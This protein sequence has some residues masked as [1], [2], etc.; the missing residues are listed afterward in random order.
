MS[1]AARSKILEEMIIEFGRKGLKL[2]QN[3][4]E[5]LKSARVLMK[6]LDASQSDRGETAPK[7]DEYLGSVEAY[8]VTE[9]GKHFPSEKVDDWLRKLDLAGCESC[10]TVVKPREEMRFIPGVPRDQKWIRVKPLASL[11]LEKL[12]QMAAETRLGFR[13]EEDGHLIVFGTG[14]DIKQFIAKMTEQANK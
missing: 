13:E 4:L 9:A 2:P 7:I 5:D 3:V 1:Y 8:L 14:E 11:P 10:V 6:V 12:E